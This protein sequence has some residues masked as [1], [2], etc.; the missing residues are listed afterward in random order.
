MPGTA[1]AIVA[2][3]PLMSKVPLET[4]EKKKAAATDKLNI[5]GIGIGGRG[6]GVTENSVPRIL[7]PCAMLTGGIRQNSSKISQR[8]KN[9]DFRKLFMK[10][11]TIS[12]P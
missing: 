7:S 1:G 11:E 4:Q 5:A 3:T 8:Q 12:M 6:G 2:S 10:W 9:K